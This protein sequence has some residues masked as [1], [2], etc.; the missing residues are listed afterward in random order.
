M[1]FDAW[2]GSMNLALGAVR[3][4]SRYIC[5]RRT[6]LAPREYVS[7]SLVGVNGG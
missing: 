2:T 6:A 7:C 4:V 1:L 3:K 5:K